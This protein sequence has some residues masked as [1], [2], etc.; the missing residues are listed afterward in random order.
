MDLP[1]ISV[2]KSDEILLKMKSSVIDFFNITPLHYLN[3]GDE[4]LKHFNFLLNVVISDVNNAS[5]KELNTVYALLLHK[6]HSKLKTSDR[7]YRKIST[8]PFLAKGLDMY[9]KELHLSKW[10]SNSVSS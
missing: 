5:V 3:A 6:G 4:G 1:E 7:S 8:C 9:I 10:N 2:K